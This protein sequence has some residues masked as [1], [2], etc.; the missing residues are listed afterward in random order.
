M[1]LF[2]QIALNPRLLE[3]P[4]GFGIFIDRRVK[5][6]PQIWNNVK[7]YTRILVYDVLTKNKKASILTYLNRI[8]L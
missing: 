1:L 8:T 7:I 2:K 5:I 3:F 4:N 6:K